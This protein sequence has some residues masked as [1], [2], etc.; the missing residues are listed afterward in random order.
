M[1]AIGGDISNGASIGQSLGR[2]ESSPLFL[3]F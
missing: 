2:N 1:K 3:L